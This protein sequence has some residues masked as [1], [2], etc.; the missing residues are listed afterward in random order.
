MKPAHKKR[1]SSSLQ[2]VILI[3]V[4]ILFTFLA[5]RVSYSFAVAAFTSIGGFLIAGY[6][7][8]FIVTT[9]NFASPDHAETF[10]TL[11][12][13]LCIAI[14]M[15]L[16]YL[17][18][19]LLSRLKIPAF[20][21]SLRLLNTLI[22]ENHFL[23]LRDPDILMKFF[24]SVEY[25]PRAN[26]IAAAIYPSLVM[27]GTIAH[28]IYYGELRNAFFIF[29]GITSAIIIYVF[30]TFV[31]A[32]L[33][34]GELRRA[35]KRFLVMHHIHF[36]EIAYSSIKKKFIFINILVLIAMIELALMF[37]NLK[38]GFFSL[39]P[40]VY[41]MLTAMVVGSLLFFYLI[42]IEDALLEIESAALDLSKGGRGKLYGRSLDKEIIN[43]SQ[44]IIAAAYEVN[45]IRN[46]L[47][48]MVAKRTD[49]LKHSLAEI[50]IL[51]EKQDGDYYLTSLLIDA[52]SNY[53]EIKSDKVKV[54]F[55]VEQHKKFTFRRWNREIGGDL[56]M[57]SSVLL[58]GKPYTIFLNADAMGKSIQGAGGLL[59]LGSAIKFL[60]YRTKNTDSKKNRMYPEIWLREAFQDLQNIFESFDGTMMVSLIFGLVDDQSGLIYFINA[61]HPWSII[62][63]DKKARFAETG[64]HL[65]KIG[66]PFQ[67]QAKIYIQTL[68]L[69][70]GDIYITGS[71]G[72]DDV[73]IGSSQDTGQRVINEDETLILDIIQNAQA[74]LKEIAK[75]LRQKGELT[76]D[77]SLMRIEFLRT[78]N[79]PEPEI[80]D[81]ISDL[82]KRAQQA[83]R[84][85][86]L[87][88]SLQLVNEAY[89]LDH[90]HQETLKS[91]VQIS[92]AQE[93]YN[94]ALYY[95]DK[96]LH[97]FPEDSEYFYLASL[98]ARYSE[99]LSHAADY[100]ER[101]RLRAPYHLPNL[102]NL[103][104]TYD[105]LGMYD[106]AHIIIQEAK[107]INPDDP[108]VQKH[109]QQLSFG[110]DLI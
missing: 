14:Y 74:D 26:M 50:S 20:P 41:I 101:L 46:N 27:I 33:L 58:R 24:R 104:E 65:R 8:I 71:D 47:E 25:L 69:Q 38:P 19:G 98:C 57:A 13:I 90:Y 67:E 68:M 31:I 42:S 39:M 109:Y 15:P 103:C 89:Q 81:R 16:Y 88:A 29:I 61:E 77:L 79:Q 55:L 28:E 96:Y 6:I 52:L 35:T 62:Y 93:Q 80:Q 54:D 56:C 95:A 110:A 83:R 23:S 76:D 30:Y 51:K 97:Q 10:I 36:G 3:P 5:K 43:M 99:Q 48:Q 84:A 40:W 66:T 49:E 94:K 73:V 59:V 100:G 86:D 78:Q 4:D 7:G 44:G 60:L 75:Q 22:R 11:F 37:F 87:E 72:R 1:G 108:Q 18:F 106:Q 63:R 92:M 105:Q 64:M 45:D 12:L 21:K 85:N 2:R 34:T 82:L 107:N 102:I 53:K 91:L 9:V 17:H 70:P 32:E